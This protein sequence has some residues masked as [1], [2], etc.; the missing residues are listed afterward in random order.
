[1]SQYEFTAVRSCDYGIVFA[2]VRRTGVGTRTR[3]MSK[4][5]RDMQDI[6][7]FRSCLASPD[8]LV[9]SIAK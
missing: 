9:G 6:L 7:S 5:S 4:C 8:D 1:M 2:S 3:S